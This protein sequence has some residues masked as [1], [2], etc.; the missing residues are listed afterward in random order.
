MKI[1]QNSYFKCTV[2]SFVAV[3]TLSVFFEI[4]L[5]FDFLNPFTSTFN[6]VDLTDIITSKFG[7]DDFLGPDTNIVLV[8][9]GNTRK[10]IARQIEILNSHNPKLIAVDAFFEGTSSEN[11]RS[12]LFNAFQNTKELVLVYKL[13]SS[14][15]TLSNNYLLH[16]APFGNKKNIH[17]GFANIPAEFSSKTVR[18]FIPIIISH[19]SVLN[20]FCAEIAK[21]IDI[22]SYN[23]L[24]SRGNKREIINFRGNNYY[25]LASPN[26]LYRKDLSFIQ[27][28]IVIIGYLGI[29]DHDCTDKFYT[30]LNAKNIGRSLPDMY[31]VVI[32]ANILSMILHKNFISHLS[33]FL[34][35]FFLFIIF[36]INGSFLIILTKKTKKFYWFSSKLFILVEV[37]LVLYIYIL[38]YYNFSIK[39]DLK[40]LLIGL[41]L[42]PTFFETINKFF[43]IMQKDNR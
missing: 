28:K 22:D 23:Y 30:P 34:Q 1:F 11:S 12:L 17:F 20:S 41:F 7:P 3:A 18:T 15:D 27:N 40:K 38:L 4:A 31:G 32:H 2:I 6:D 42:F 9:I 26:E 21:T 24:L 8:N 13:P 19:D 14:L 43:L 37:F 29:D 36:Y 33:T 25:T 16:S 39:I 35:Y 5:N 10:E